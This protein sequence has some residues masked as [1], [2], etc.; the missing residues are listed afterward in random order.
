MYV[1]VYNE[2]SCICMNIT[3]VSVS[4]SFLLAATL[5]VTHALTIHTHRYSMCLVHFLVVLF[6]HRASFLFASLCY[7]SKQ[8]VNDSFGL[9]GN[10]EL[11]SL[12]CRWCFFFFFD[13]CCL[14]GASFLCCDV[15]AF[16]YCM[17]EGT[18]RFFCFFCISSFHSFSFS[19]SF[20]SVLFPCKRLSRLNKLDELVSLC[21]LRIKP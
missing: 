11:F 6:I 9:R 15:A 18:V 4:L 19:I 12:C 13:F 3:S 17:A 1:A 8:P 5:S 7:Y 16:Y 21:L 14:Y 10:V 2:C 20:H